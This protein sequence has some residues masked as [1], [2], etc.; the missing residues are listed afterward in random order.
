[1]NFLIRLKEKIEITIVKLNRAYG[2]VQEPNKFIIFLLFATSG[3]STMAFGQLIEHMGIVI[4][5]YIW[6]IF[7]L[8][9]RL[10]FLFFL[11]KKYPN[12]G[13]KK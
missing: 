1:M 6:I 2:R 4:L 9:V 13:K 11:A 12:A 3:L 5:G 10:W 8:S 7:L